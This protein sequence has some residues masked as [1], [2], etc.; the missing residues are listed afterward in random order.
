MKTETKHFVNNPKKATCKC[1]SVCGRHSVYTR[2]IRDIGEDHPVVW[3]V[4]TGKYNC[5]T[6]HK[7]FTIETPVA[8]HCRRYTKGV[9]RVALELVRVNTYDRA[10][11]IMRTEF[12]VDVPPTTIYEWFVRY[13]PDNKRQVRDRRGDAE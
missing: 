9:L 10:S 3:K 2:I 12:N 7:I 13:S 4:V 6:C 1:G 11:A 8:L 5:H